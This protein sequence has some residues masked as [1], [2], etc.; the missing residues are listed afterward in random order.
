LK[1][2]VSFSPDFGIEPFVIGVADFVGADFFAPAWI[3]LGLID[4]D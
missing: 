1:A 2:A 3:R 4:L